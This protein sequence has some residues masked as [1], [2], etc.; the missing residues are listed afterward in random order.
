[1]VFFL[2]GLTQFR[3]KERQIYEKQIKSAKRVKKGQW[4]KLD[5]EFTPRPPTAVSDKVLQRR[6]LE[7]PK[8]EELRVEFFVY[9]ADAGV[10]EVDNVTIHEVGPVDEAA[11]RAKEYRATGLKHPDEVEENK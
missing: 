8:V 5:F 3:G 1:M 4:S 10:V 7:I 9:G 6:N 11:E 2:Q